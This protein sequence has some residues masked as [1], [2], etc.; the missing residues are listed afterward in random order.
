MPT[1]DQ[2]TTERAGLT[3]Q[4]EGEP[5]TITRT[6]SDDPLDYVDDLEGVVREHL[7]PPVHKI[8]LKWA[9]M[10]EDTAIEDFVNAL[11]PHLRDR[12]PDFRALTTHVLVDMNK[13]GGPCAAARGGETTPPTS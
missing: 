7:P 5:F 1:H 2:S 13:E 9:A 6:P 11:E 10:N 12:A 4:A 3:R 8:A